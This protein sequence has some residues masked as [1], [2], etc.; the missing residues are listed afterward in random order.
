[1]GI[2]DSFK[3]VYDISRGDFSSTDDDKKK[4]FKKQ[5][6][7]T[8]GLLGDIQSRQDQAYKQQILELQNAL[9]AVNQKNTQALGALDQ[10]YG[11]ERR[12]VQERGQQTF[13]QGSQ[14]LSRRGLGNTTITGGL[15]RGVGE[16]VN[17]GMGQLAAAQ[18]G[19]QANLYS[20]WGG[21]QSGLY[22]RLAGIYGQQAQGNTELGLNSIPGNTQQFHSTANADLFGLIGTGLGGYFGGAGGASAGAGIGQSLGNLFDS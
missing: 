11:A 21:Q 12:A 15:R 13:A 22:G 7:K 16:D 17:R 6:R 10:T 1:M 19:Q 20:G 8:E 14:D 4:K 5:K 3:K 9:E 18:A 2:F